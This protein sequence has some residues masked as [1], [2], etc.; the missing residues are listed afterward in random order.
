MF[1]GSRGARTHA[2]R[3]STLQE[4]STPASLL[5]YLYYNLSV[6]S[7]AATIFL[8]GRLAG[9]PSGSWPIGNRPVSVERTASSSRVSGP[10]DPPKGI[11]FRSCG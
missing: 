3:V 6:S 10:R 7:Q 4:P 9:V 8:W 5:K 2:C 1:K 11:L